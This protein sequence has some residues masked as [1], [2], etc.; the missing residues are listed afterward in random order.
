[1]LTKPGLRGWATWEG[2]SR[3]GGEEPEG[4]GCS[5]DPAGLEG[6]A[7]GQT[8]AGSGSSLNLTVPEHQKVEESTNM[9]KLLERIRP[10]PPTGHHHGSHP[11]RRH[12]EQVARAA[13]SAE[14]EAQAAARLGGHGPRGP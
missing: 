11:S 3:E 4:R 8:A 14:P 6:Q 2:D 5:T 10:Q 1:M 7:R 9:K 12:H 13:E